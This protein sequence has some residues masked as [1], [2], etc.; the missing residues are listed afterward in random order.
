MNLGQKATRSLKAGLSAEPTLRERPSR[1]TN[2]PW[3][4]GHAI[5]E[6]GPIGRADATRTSIAFN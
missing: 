4:K 3:P 5:A 6:S 1:S 2:Q